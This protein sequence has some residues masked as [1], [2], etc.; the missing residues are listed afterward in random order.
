MEPVTQFLD[1]CGDLVKFDRFSAAVALGYKH[2]ASLLRGFYEYYF[3]GKVA[4]ATPSL[5]T[6]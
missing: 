3:W 2:N 5:L 6:L 4:R 1:P